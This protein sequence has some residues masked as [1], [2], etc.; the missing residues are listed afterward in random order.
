M[1]VL[2]VDTMM[3]EKIGLLEKGRGE[4]ET[5]A[6]DAALCQVLLEDGLLDLIASA[7]GATRVGVGGA[8]AC[9]GRGTVE[10]LGYLG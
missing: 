4:L 3:R 6:V 5:A 1:D 7:K 10:L 8:A 2:N 9:V